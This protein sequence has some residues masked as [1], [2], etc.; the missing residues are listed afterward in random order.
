MVL[1]YE[2]QIT[3]IEKKSKCDYNKCE[4]RS[5]MDKDE[6]FLGLFLEDDLQFYDKYL[7]EMTIEEL[8][9]FLEENQAFLEDE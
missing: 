4:R 3:T 5:K 7:S 1:L 9:A 2:S 6:K 8:E